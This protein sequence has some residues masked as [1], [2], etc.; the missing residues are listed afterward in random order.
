MKTKEITIQVEAEAADIYQSS[1]E[2]KKRKLDALLS[3]RLREVTSRRISEKSLED[4]M[5]EISQKARA[6]GLTPTK[7][8]EILNE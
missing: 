2:E 5:H 7:L 3:S 4:I 8:D 6:R 1:S